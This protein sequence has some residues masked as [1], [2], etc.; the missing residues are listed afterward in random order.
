MRSRSERFYRLFMLFLPGSLR[1]GFQNA[2]AHDFLMRLGKARGPFGKAVV[3]TG[4][5]IDLI[6]QGMAEFIRLRRQQGHESRI[7]RGGSA[8]DFFRQDLRLAARNLRRK[9]SFTFI[10]AFT[11]ALGIGGTIALSSVVHSVMFR[12]LPF[13]DEEGIVVFWAPYSWTGEEFDFIRE[14][15]PVFESVAAFSNTDLTLREDAASIYL[16]AANVSSDLFEVLGAEPL[17]GRTFREGDDRPGAEPSIV[18]SHG[19]WRQEFGSDRAIVGRSVYVNGTPTTVIGVMPEGFYFPSIGLRAW[20]PLNLDPSAQ[21]YRSN[22]WLVLVGRTLPG[23]TEVQLRGNLTGLGQTLGGRFTYSETSIKG[24]IPNVTPLRQY[25]LGDRQPVVL[26]LMIAVG[27]LL[28]MASA[29]VMSLVL[30]RGLGRLDEM[31]VR[32]ALGAGRGRLSRLVL[33][34]T[35]LLGLVAGALGVLLAVFSF[36]GLVASLPLDRGFRDTLSLNWTSLLVGLGLAMVLGT[37]ISLAPIRALWRG[38]Q[39]GPLLSGHRNAGMGARRSRLQGALVFAE[40]F[41]AVVLSVSAVLLIRSVENLR[42]LDPGLNPEGVL[43]LDIVL[44]QEESTP[45]ERDQFFRSVVEDTEAR[46]GVLSAGLINRLPIRDGGWQ[47]GISVEGGAEVEGGGR[48]NA[49]RRGV[50]PDVFRTLGVQVVRGRGIETGD[51][52][53]TRRVAVINETFADRVWPGEDPIGKRVQFVWTRESAEIVGVVRDVSVVGLVGETPMAVYYAWDQAMAGSG[54]ATLVLKSDQN[55]AS[56]ASSVRQTLADIDSRAAVGDVET[57]DQVVERALADPLRLRFFFT[58][59]SVLGLL[60]GAVGIYGVVSYGVRLR[61]RELGIRM[62]LG[63]S[64]GGMASWVVRNGMLPVLGGA[65]AG[66][67]AFLASSGFMARFLFGVN[68]SDPGSVMTG[69]GA[70]ILAGAIAALIP[71]LRAGRTDPAETMRVE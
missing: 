48:P 65:L 45:E 6:A 66:I 9:P 16:E 34:E 56:L 49:Y 28:V 67:L 57:M 60:L 68:P 26:L 59:F 36:G 8:F 71:A 44:G 10:A 52:L 53:G 61:K 18:L 17:L 31:V 13:V 40:V 4:A 32:T 33:T 38:L 19:L 39:P 15:M 70:L 41:V 11:L 1:T 35:L 30:T 24:G 42:A 29:N 43:A 2:M 14:Q 20:L 54:R 47:G 62:V 51:R 12:P 5:V 55:P 63:A 27:L 46:P 22:S 64:P 25:L 7:C 69:A 23:A 58:L 3:W 50:T 21:A 37:I